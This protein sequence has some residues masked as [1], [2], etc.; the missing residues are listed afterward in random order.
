MLSFLSLQN[1]NPVKVI[2]IG[3]NLVGLALEDLSNLRFLRAHERNKL[4]YL[5]MKSHA[6]NELHLE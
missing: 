5:G 3:F 1:F 2:Y 4:G 6:P